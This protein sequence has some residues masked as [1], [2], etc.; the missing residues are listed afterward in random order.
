MRYA[1]YDMHTGEIRQTIDCSP[2]HLVCPDEEGIAV[3]PV[4]DWV[5]D[6]LYYIEEEEP[7]KKGDISSLQELPL[8][9]TVLI[10]GVTYYC[11]EQ[12]DFEFDAPGTY[13]VFVDAGP[14]YL[15]KEFIIEN[16]A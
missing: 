11:T 3:V 8:P 12:P 7:H 6:D 4:P 2:K 10:E 15:R 16:P 14:H 9:C 5:T 13:H 1:V